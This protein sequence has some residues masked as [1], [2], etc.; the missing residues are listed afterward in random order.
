MSWGRGIVALVVVAWLGGVAIAGVDDHHGA[1][2]QLAALPI[3]RATAEGFGG[4]IRLTVE[5]AT[6]V[7]VTIDA[8]HGGSDLPEVTVWG[9]PKV[10]RCHPDAAVSFPGPRSIPKLVDGATSQVVEVE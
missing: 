3:E 8:D 6:D 1:D 4:R 10:G 5:C 7:A 9:R 2:S